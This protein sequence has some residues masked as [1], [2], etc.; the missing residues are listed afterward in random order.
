MRIRRVP[1]PD[2]ETLNQMLA[3]YEA[4]FPANQRADLS[5]L[6]QG[7]EEDG[8]LLYVA[9]EEGRVVAF[10]LLDPLSCGRVYLLGYIAVA[11]EQRGQGV[12]G[13]LLGHIRDDLR[14]REGA[15]GLLLEVEPP[16]EGPEQE[17]ATRRRRV[18]FYE[19]QGAR[20]IC[21][22]ASYRMPNLAGE[23]SLPMLLMWLPV[24]KQEP[25]SG[26]QLRKCIIHIYTESYGRDEEDA[27]LRS[28]LAGM[29]AR[30][31]ASPLDGEYNNDCGQG[32]R[33]KGA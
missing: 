13:A 26:D 6:D 29:G 28:I 8:P 33:N 31:V 12:G 19:R 21:E 11:V 17:R 30:Q 27:L 15:E 20:V 16:D 25:P 32:Q 23:G 10:A 1:V 18:H 3:I 5:A 9:S 7:T 22:A 4:S 14:A 24:G 2:R